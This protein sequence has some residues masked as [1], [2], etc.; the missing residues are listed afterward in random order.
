LL[1]CS[2]RLSSWPVAGRHLSSWSRSWLV[3]GIV[4]RRSRR[5]QAWS[6]SVVVA[7]GGRSLSVGHRRQLSL[8]VMA[9]T[10]THLVVGAARHRCHPRAHAQCVHKGTRAHTFF[11]SSFASSRLS[12][13]SLSSCSNHAYESKSPSSVVTPAKYASFSHARS[14]CNAA[15]TTASSSSLIVG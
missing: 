10:V 6:W 13:V 2:G 4:G 12:A 7:I 14:D 5:G 15:S 11:T 1:P 8:S 9:V 3:V